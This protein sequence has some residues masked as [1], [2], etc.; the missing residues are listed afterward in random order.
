[1]TGNFVRL[2]VIVQKR[3]IVSALPFVKYFTKIMAKVSQLNGTEAFDSWRYLTYNTRILS[4]IFKC[5]LNVKNVFDLGVKMGIAADPRGAKGVAKYLNTVKKEYGEL[6]EKDK[7]YFDQSRLANPYPDS[8]IHVD[9]GRKD[10]KRVIAG[11]D[12]DSAEILMATQ[13]TERGKKIDLAISHH[14]VG[15]ALAGLHEVMEMSTGV[16]ESFGLPIHIAEK[17]MG[18]RIN[19]VGRGVHGINH[20]RGVDIARILGVNYMSTHTIT[21]NLV[22]QF[23]E[24]LFKKEKPETMGEMMDVL[25][26]IPEYQEAKRRG[27]GPKII[28]G[29][30]HKK[31]GKYLVEMTGGTE[32]SA[33]V[34]EEFSRVGYSTIIGM[35]MREDGLK[36]VNEQ[37]MNVII[38]G[39]MSS[40][41]IGM[42]LFLDELEKK[43]VDIVPCGGLIRVS[44]NKKKWF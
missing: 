20:H 42:N 19:E 22:N 2:A 9:D 3:S 39:H 37:H 17:V 41:S 40:D 1:M 35:H 29:N 12:L 24:D 44:R 14:P 31:V 34:Y 38:A 11:I 8:Y 10:V 16:F 28:A 30:R 15:N 26:E 6:K 36:K 5:M 23:L 7:K 43:G 18:D 27:A 13:L 4:L 21:D 32:P 25:M 33:Q